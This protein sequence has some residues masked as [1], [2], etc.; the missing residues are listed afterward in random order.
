MKIKYYQESITMTG[1]NKMIGSIGKKDKSKHNSFSF[2]DR[3]SNES[4]SIISRINNQDETPI[5]RTNYENDMYSEIDVSYETKDNFKEIPIKCKNNNVFVCEMCCESNDI[6]FIILNCNH[7]YHII[8]LANEQIEYS[9]QCQ[10]IDNDTFFSKMKCNCGELLESSEI[11]MIQN[12]FYKGTDNY[13][14]T[15]DIKINKLDE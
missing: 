5:S 4:E 3:H 14:Q 1:F 7:I 12:K 11:M 10:I 15:H 8:C 9:R 13:I 2:G 6:P